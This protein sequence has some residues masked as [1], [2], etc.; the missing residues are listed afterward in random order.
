MKTR[1]DHIALLEAFNELAWWAAERPCPKPPELIPGFTGMNQA[2]MLDYKEKLVA[3][4]AGKAE[5][6]LRGL[7]P[8]GPCTDRC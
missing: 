2:R 7:R 4:K 6:L 8:R 5:A 3:W 1:E